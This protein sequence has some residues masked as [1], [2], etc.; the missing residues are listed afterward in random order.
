MLLGCGCNC[1]GER[2]ILVPSIPK[3]PSLSASV[4]ESVPIIVPGNGCVTC[5][6]N[7]APTVYQCTWSYAGTPD[8]GTATPCC[9]LYNGQS[10]FRLYRRELLPTQDPNCCVWSSD[11]KAGRFAADATTTWCELSDTARVALNMG[12]GLC[13]PAGP[14][15]SPFSELRLF[16]YYIER[17][18]NFSWVSYAP[19]VGEPRVGP[20]N[21]LSTITLAIEK[22][23]NQFYPFPGPQLIKRWSG[24]TQLSGSGS[25]CLPTN[26]ITG[27]DAGI[28]DTVTLVPVPL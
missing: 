6:D 8:T 11:E 2:S 19:A 27:E 13:T 15:T 25:P 4:S 16:V 9:G 20:I 17:N 5:R 23:Y 18:N 1:V 24:W 14:S 12:Q 21:C 7:A 3:D 10:V 28:P 26:R 22:R